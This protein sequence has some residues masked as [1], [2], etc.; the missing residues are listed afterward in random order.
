MIVFR[1]SIRLSYDT[2]AIKQRQGACRYPPLIIQHSFS[3]NK[4]WPSGCVAAWVAQVFPSLFHSLYQ[5]DH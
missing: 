3:F 2:T 4:Q 1:V 5:S